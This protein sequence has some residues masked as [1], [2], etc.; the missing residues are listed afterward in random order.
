[1]ARLIEV[2]DP[3]SA[4]L[5]ECCEALTVWGFDPAE[6]ES[7]SHAASWLGRLG[8]DRSFLADCLIDWLAGRRSVGEASVAVDGAQANR[9]LLSTPGRGDFA[10]VASIWPSP[11]EAVFRASG[12]RAF[13]Y[14]VAH[15]HNFDFLRL[16]YF[17]PGLTVDDFEYD[18]TQVE[19]WHDE[20]VDL[21]LLGRT[22]FDRGRLVHYR[23]NRDVQLHHPPQSLSASL[24][25]VHLHPAQGW[26][27]HYLFD[28]DAGRISR[29]LGH[30]PSEAFLRIAVGLGSEEA[31]DLAI[32]FGRHHPSAR[33]RIAAWRALASVAKDEAA[34]DEVWR[35]AEN[36]GSR[37]VAATVRRLRG[38]E[39]P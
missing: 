36:S 24:A 32:R 14:G 16:G 38:A 20:P 33:M 28:V 27:D 9:I 17:G 12:A 19:G 26:T 35:E 34:R 15:D 2:R 7:I 18:H 25:V 29:V 37:A 4:T 11:Q 21:R 30:G 6:G 31:K 39:V 1:M 10:I 13:G 8:N 22:Q 23:A 3:T 5:E